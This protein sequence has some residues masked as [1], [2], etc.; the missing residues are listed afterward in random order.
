MDDEAG[1]YRS[2]EGFASDDMNGAQ[3]DISRQLN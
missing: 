2:P 1:D 3:I